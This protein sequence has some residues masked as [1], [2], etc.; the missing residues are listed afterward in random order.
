LPR[1]AKSV[2]S[3]AGKVAS[4]GNVVRVRKETDHVVESAGK[5]SVVLAALVHRASVLSDHRV[6]VVL[7]LLVHRASRVSV[8]SDR[9]ASERLAH[10]VHRASVS[11]ASH[12]QSSKRLPPIR[13]PRL[14]HSRRRHLIIPELL[15]ASKRYG[16]GLL[17][18]AQGELRSCY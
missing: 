16:A 4:V 15:R 13:Q 18:P 2:V 3:A 17:F 1:L 6:S 8:L 14:Q 10:L 11:P 12:V 9:R 5:V 7:A